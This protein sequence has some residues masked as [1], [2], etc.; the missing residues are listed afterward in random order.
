MKTENYTPIV[1]VCYHYNL[2][3]SFFVEL[4][5]MGLITLVEEQNLYYIEVE[6][7]SYLEK[8][9]HL[10]QDL[11]INL[12]GIDVLLQI[13]I[14]ISELNQEINSLKNQLAIHQSSII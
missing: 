14:R 7:V 10:H 3:I 1:D 2:E 12:E 9:I 5:D 13:Q 6:N 8:I 4:Q 11:Q